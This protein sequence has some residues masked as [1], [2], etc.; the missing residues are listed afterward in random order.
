MITVERSMEKKISTELP[1]TQAQRYIDPPDHTHKSI[2]ALPAE[3]QKP[4]GI[5][6]SLTRPFAV[7]VL[8]SMM[9][10]LVAGCCRPLVAKYSVVS[11]YLL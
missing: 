11:F 10:A 8:W 6:L 7:E 9:A 1:S 2:L 3:D 4:C 5:P